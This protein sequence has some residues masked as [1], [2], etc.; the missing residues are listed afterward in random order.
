MEF[1]NKIID[2]LIKL[3]KDPKIKMKC[4]DWSTMKTHCFSDRW[5]VVIANYNWLKIVD[6]NY[7]EHRESNNCAVNIIQAVDIGHE[8]WYVFAKKFIEKIN[9]YW[10][11]SPVIQILGDFMDKKPSAKNKI[12]KNI[13][14]PTL[15]DTTP[16]DLSQLYPQDYVNNM[17]E[18]LE[19]VDRVIPWFKNK[20]NLLYGPFVERWTDEIETNQFFET[21]SKW[22]YVIWDWAGKVQWIVASAIQ[23]IVCADHIIECFD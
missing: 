17:L 3:T 5:I 10:H 9:K 19:K 20:Y 23:W 8:N 6:W 14:I 12:E 21:K 11:W 7:L 1:E 2:D 18:F 22:L 15:K 16:W 4:A 13:I